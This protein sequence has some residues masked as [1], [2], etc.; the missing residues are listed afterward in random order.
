PPAGGPMAIDLGSDP[1]PSIRPMPPEPWYY[2][3]LVRYA[4]LIVIVGVLQF[5]FMLLGGFQAM[6]TPQSP[7]DQMATGVLVAFLVL[8]SLVILIGCGAAGGLILLA[9]DA[10]RNVRANR[11]RG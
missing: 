2:G 6:G 5:G 8:W 7:G 11:Y 4:Y 9:V 10:A 3:Y 1:R